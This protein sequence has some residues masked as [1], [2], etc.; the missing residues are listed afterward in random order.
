ME[1][2]EIY[3]YTPYKKK[4][5]DYLEIGCTILLVFIVNITAYFHYGRTFA[6]FLEML[7]LIC[8]LITRS[9]KLLHFILY[10]LVLE[11]IWKFYP[12]ISNVLLLPMLIAIII[13]SIIVLLFS[14]YQ[15]WFSWLNF[16][17]ITS[18]LWLLGVLTIIVS[19]VTLII[20][21]YWTNNLGSGELCISLIKGYSL[22]FIILVIIP[23][24]AIV[25]AF[26][27]ELFFRGIIQ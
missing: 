9:P 26:M 19:V 24:F 6:V 4:L 13:S 18:A 5:F 8:I 12:Y 7:I 2:S 10:V 22:T 14:T 3:A 16:G 11:V 17:V 1:K 15:Y 21:A 23:L 25:N 20:W 27:E